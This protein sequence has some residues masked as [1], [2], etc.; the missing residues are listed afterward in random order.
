MKKKIKKAIKEKR[1]FDL[2]D[3]VIEPLFIKKDTGI[4]QS[5]KAQTT[6]YWLI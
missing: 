4:S 2:I 1:L 6:N 3:L 5:W